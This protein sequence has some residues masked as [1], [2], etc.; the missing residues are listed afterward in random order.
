MS[1]QSWIVLIILILTVSTSA[2]ASGGMKEPLRP[3]VN[4]M[5][6]ARQ[7]TEMNG[8]AGLSAPESFE[9]LKKA[10]YL[11]NMDLMYKAVYKAFSFRKQEALNFSV[12]YLRSPLTEISGTTVVSRLREFTVAKRIF[13]TFPEDAAMI[14]VPLY[15]RSD[16]VTRANI[17]KAAG[18]V[19]G[20]QEIRALFMRALNDRTAYEDE[21]PDSSGRP[22]RICDMAYNQLVLRY[23]IR[24]VLRTISPVHSIND[25]DYHIAILRGM[26]S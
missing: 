22:M 24:N 18:R 26:L 4:R 19:A 5:F 15:D 12:M 3:N 21:N 25:R 9:R 11:M 17:L 10:E 16:E 13:E 8:L 6:D 23:G 1:R 14:L 7:E 2:D 20:G